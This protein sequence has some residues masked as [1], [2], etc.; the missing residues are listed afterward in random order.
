MNIYGSITRFLFQHIGQF[1]RLCG[2]L[3]TEFYQRLHS[4]K[5]VPQEKAPDIVKVQNYCDFRKSIAK[6][7]PGAPQES[8]GVPPKSPGV[9]WQGFPYVG[10]QRKCPVRAFWL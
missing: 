2:T 4:F 1:F 8:P 5:S 10:F 3:Q 7:R 6:W 9:P